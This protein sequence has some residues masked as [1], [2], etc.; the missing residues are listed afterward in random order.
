M[1]VKR[2]VTFDSVSE[3]PVGKS[4]H[5]SRLVL[6]KAQDKFHVVRCRES[7][8]T[9]WIMI[10]GVTQQRTLAGGVAQHLSVVVVLWLGADHLGTNVTHTCLH[11]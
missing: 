10:A 4:V 3:A 6:G 9:V 5:G 8:H 2:N 1:R 7:L 11:L